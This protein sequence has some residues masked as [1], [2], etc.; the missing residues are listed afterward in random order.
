MV[1]L[2]NDTEIVEASRCLQVC[3]RRFHDPGLREPGL[4]V[5]SG[6]GESHVFFFHAIFVQHQTDL[7]QRKRR[8]KERKKKKKQ[9]RSRRLVRENNLNALMSSFEGRPRGE[10]RQ[11]PYQ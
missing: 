10:K 3:P 7:K 6:S 2:P 4:V 11:R 9:K 5:T 1:N 8:K